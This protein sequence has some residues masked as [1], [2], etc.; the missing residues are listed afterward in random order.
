V[1]VLLEPTSIIE[2]GI[3]QAYEL[4]RRLRVWQP[5]RAAV[6]GAGTVGLLATMGMRLRGIEVVTLGLDEPPYLNSDLIEAL[7]A[8]YISTKQTPLAKVAEESGPLDLIYECTG[9]SPLVFEAMQALG[10]NGV[11]VLASVTGGDTKVEVPSDAINQG[12]VL[13]NKAMVGTVNAN[14]EHFEAGVR[15]LTM[16]QALW[17]GWLERLLT[18]RV[19]G[20]SEW[21]KAFELLGH[22]GVIKVFVEVAE[23]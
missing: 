12:F 23:A 16:A 17:P 13:G 19:E 9:F 8:T 2:K 11:L 7:G 18:D 1:G 22:P 20:L 15:D 21:P 10:K 3:A 4:Q 14:R 6:L 5:K